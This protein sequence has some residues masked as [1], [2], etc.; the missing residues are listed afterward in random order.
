MGNSLRL[1]R[2]GRGLRRFAQARG[3]ATSLA[4]RLYDP[5]SEAYRGQQTVKRHLF[6]ARARKIHPKGKNC[7]STK[8]V[9]MSAP[10]GSSPRNASL[11]RGAFSAVLSR[12][13][14]G[15]GQGGVWRR[16]YTA[17]K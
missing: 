4:G 15:G 3:R 16:Q 6:S 2:T 5:G 17:K 1:A 8:C 7:A 9:R 10:A 14:M 11:L 13:T 12:K